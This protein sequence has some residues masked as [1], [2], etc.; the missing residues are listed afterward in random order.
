MGNTL[1]LNKISVDLQLQDDIPQITADAGELQQVFFNI[2]NNAI[3]AMQGGGLLT[4]STKAID[5][6]VGIRIADTGT[7]IKREYHSRIFDP[8]FTTK[9]VG[10]GT[11]LG[12]SVS[13]GIVTTHHGSITF[14]T[15]T[16]EESE[17]TGT[18][19]I[20]MFPAVNNIK[21]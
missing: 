5:H 14:E 21:T 10:K 6:N 3:Y 1:L 18:T 20:I 16:K 8:L 17:E 19:F 12:L 9:D 7:G 4:I 2:I 11:G 15:R 13:Y